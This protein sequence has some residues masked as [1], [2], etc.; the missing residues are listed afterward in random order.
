L[1]C[2]PVAQWPGFE[3]RRRPRPVWNKLGPARIGSTT[4]H[5]VATLS[6]H[7]GNP[8]LSALHD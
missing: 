3:T 1:R 2:A 6:D 4:D 5:G 7:R 8:C